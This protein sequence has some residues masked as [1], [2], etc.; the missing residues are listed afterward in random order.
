MQVPVVEVKQ[1]GSVAVVTIN[2]PEAKNAL[3]P[4]VMVRLDR[5]WTDLGGDDDV[6]AIVLTGSGGIFSAGADLKLLVPVLTGARQPQDDFEQVVVDD[7]LT[8]QRGALRIGDVGKPLI[9]AVEGAA[10]AGGFEIVLGCDLRIASAGAAFALREARLGLIPLGGGTARLPR[11]I[12]RTVALEMLL[13]GDTVTAER[14][15]E[16]GLV[17]RVVPEGSAVEAAVEMAGRIAA[18]G[19]LS[20]AA[21][22][23]IVREG[24][25]LGE[26]AALDLETEVGAEVFASEDARE[27]P[28][29]FAEKRAPEFKGR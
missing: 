20:V 26:N 27:G 7:P 16:L 24:S 14:L 13:T 11:L 15:H 8:I 5:A 12:P 28:R 10:Y 1:S 19:P 2:R 22:R 17:N 4:E 25:D 29:A 6:R 18:N 9:A 23:R 21:L 3:S